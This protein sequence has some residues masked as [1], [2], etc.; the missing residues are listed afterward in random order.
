MLNANSRDFCRFISYVL[1]ILF[2][3][4]IYFIY[5]LTAQIKASERAAGNHDFSVGQSFYLTVHGFTVGQGS[6]Y[7]ATLC[8]A[9]FNAQTK[10]IYLPN[11]KYRHFPMKVFKQC[12]FIFGVAEWKF[13]S[14]F[15][16]QSWG[17]IGNRAVHRIDTWMNFC[18]YAA[19]LST[20]Q[21]SNIRKSWPRVWQL[22]ESLMSLLPL[23]ME[24]L[25]F[26][27]YLVA[28]P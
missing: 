28:M 18:P 13:I 12:N 24:L 7:W 5:A 2:L 3:I 1:Y 20:F 9:L 17:W 6:F 22:P 23:F 19:L 14:H 8:Q 27:W 26:V 11:F 10:C 25:T 21:Y 16:H 15:S 4:H